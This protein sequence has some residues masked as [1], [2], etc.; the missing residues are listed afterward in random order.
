MAE[1]RHRTVLEIGVDDRQLRS[2]G[3]TLDKALSEKA[4]DAFE[5]SLERTA[6][7]MQKIVEAQGKLLKGQEDLARRA[8]SPQGGRRG[9]L[10]GML[11]GM[12]LGTGGGLTGAADAMAGAG[13]AGE[14]GASGRMAGG[15]W[16]G[17][18]GIGRLAHAGLTHAGNIGGAVMNEGFLGSILGGLPFVGPMISGAIGGANAFYQAHV[19]RSRAQAGAY[20]STRLTGYG[21]LSNRYGLGPTELPSTVGSFA[22]AAGVRG[23]GEIG[24]RWDL[25]ADLANLA[26]IDYGATGGFMRAAGGAALGR[27]RSATSETRATTEMLSAAIVAGVEESQLGQVL[28]NLGST[29]EDLQ[30][31]GF[32]I[33]PES[34]TGIIRGLSRMRTFGGM[35]GVR[36]ATGFG[37][38]LRGA[39][40]NPQDDLF[41]MFA[42]EAAGYGNDASFME[43]RMRLS[44]ES[45]SMSQGEVLQRLISRL[46]GMMSDPSDPRQ[47][48][49]LAS[50]LMRGFSGMGMALSPGQAMDIAR[51]GFSMETGDSAEYS[52]YR[53]S[54]GAGE[55]MFG[56]SRAEAAYEEGRANIG[57]NG[58]VGELVRAVR[59]LELDVV[60]STLP[61]VAGLLADAVHYLQGMFDAFQEGGLAG[62]ASMVLP[63]L[64][65]LASNVAEGVNSAFQGLMERLGITDSTGAGIDMTTFD[66]VPMRRAI[67]EALR[68]YFQPTIDEFNIFF[69]GHASAGRVPM[70]PGLRGADVEVGM[71]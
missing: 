67:V 41:Q 54:L 10:T 25:G 17:G 8:R 39:A 27:S 34:M 3:Q 50:L 11:V 37:E 63:D 62:V 13:L 69:H 16:L 48:E 18:R 59:G 66:V 49:A 23:L 52:D 15:A 24:P 30:T 61:R 1:Q 32:M 56:V 5:K 35:A 29:F 22:E 20:G 57:S 38:G 45:E 4:V 47:Q 40:M 21:G 70:L 43:A 60:N 12:A 46:R 51:E 71:G 6:A 42:Y 53:A 68:E 33:S 14:Y 64:G 2:L 9:G 26:G 31:R 58:A 36:G 7:S 65:D 19:A 44:G 28:S 55:E